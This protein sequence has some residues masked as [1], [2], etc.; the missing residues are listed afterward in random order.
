MIPSNFSTIEWLIDLKGQF[1]EKLMMANLSCC[2]RWYYSTFALPY[3]D[4][5]GIE[6]RRVDDPEFFRSMAYHKVVTDLPH[7]L[8]GEQQVKQNLLYGIFHGDGH[9]KNLKKKYFPIL[10]KLDKAGWEP[11]PYAKADCSEIIIER[12]GHEENLYFVIHNKNNVNAV[13][14]TIRFSPCLEI[15]DGFIINALTKEKYHVRN[16]IL[17]INIAPL[18]TIVIKNQSE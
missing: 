12:Y 9:D 10:Q 7:H 14:G 1:P 2:N 16:N 5:F 11:I 15:S 6:D 17:K 3:L 13:T 18:D 8:R 4:I